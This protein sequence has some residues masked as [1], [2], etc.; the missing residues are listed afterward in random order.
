M[1]RYLVQRTF[2]D[3]LNIPVNAE[4]AKSCL[5]VADGNAGL[6]VTWLHS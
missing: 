5:A 2:P 3:G 1:P 4:G 6:G